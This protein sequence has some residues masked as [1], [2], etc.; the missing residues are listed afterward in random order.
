MLLQQLMNGISQG[1]VYALIAVGYTMVYGII[2]LINFAHGEIYMLGAFF[3]MAVLRATGMPLLPAALIGIVGAIVVGVLVERVAY[4]PLRKSSRLAALISA[5]GMSIFL[6]ELARVIWGPQRQP[7]VS[8]LGWLGITH[9]IGGATFRNIEGVILVVAVVLMFLL[10]L[11]ITRSPLGMAMRCCAQDKTASR[12]MGIDVDRTISL[13]FA[14][15]SALG[16]VAGILAALTYQN[17]APN[18]G[19]VAGM[20]AFSAAV[21]GGIGNIRGAFLGGMV[22][23][24]LESLAAGYIS[25][26]WTDALAFLVLIAVILYRPQ[27]L[28]GESLPDRA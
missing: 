9:S 25:S 12:L 5:L 21:L 19:F 7:I 8:D 6:Q 27:G 18:M 2:E 16:A 3:T 14:I 10:H 15:G 4:R 23:G 22:L 11:F 28:L 17:I 20:K 13:T 1:A 24:M 26:L